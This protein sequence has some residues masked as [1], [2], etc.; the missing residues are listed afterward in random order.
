MFRDPVN[1]IHNNIEE[2]TNG[3]LQPGQDLPPQ[4]HEEVKSNPKLKPMP[5]IL[6]PGHDKS[7]PAEDDLVKDK[8]AGETGENGGA[9]IAEKKEEAMDK[10]AEEEGKEVKDEGKEKGKEESKEEAKDE[11][12]EEKKEE[13]KDDAGQKSS[14]GGDAEK[15]E[16]AE[17]VEDAESK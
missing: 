4:W 15:T 2:I 17:K 14:E 3:T 9:D 8:S 12:K 5:V 7:K 1:Q 11:V 16:S 13:T 10:K 6:P